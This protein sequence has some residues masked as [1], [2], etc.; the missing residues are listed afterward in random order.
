MMV[1]CE[2]IVHHGITKLLV[3][4]Y[5]PL[6]YMILRSNNPCLPTAGKK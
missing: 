5:Q 3:F 2:G 4:Q 6:S 1:I